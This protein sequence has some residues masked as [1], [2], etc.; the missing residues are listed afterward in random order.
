M[1]IAIL[2]TR[3]IPSNYGGFET[4][5]EE[6][7]VR[8]VQYG[9]QVTV[10]CRSHYVSY[11]QKE[12]RGVHLVI[13]PTIRHKYLD[14]VFHTFLS[15]LHCLVRDYQA[16]LI[17]NAV[18][19]AFSFIPRLRGQKVAVNV[20]GLER[21]RKKWNW[22]G[23]SAYL[24]SEHLVTILPNAIVADSRFIQSYYRNR[25]GKTSTFIAYGG[26]GIQTKQTDALKKYGL[27]KDRYLL[28]VARLEPENN[29]HVVIREFEKVR[30]TM[31]LAMVGDAPYSDSYIGGLKASRDERIRFLG[32][33]YGKPYRQILSH[34]YLSVRASEVGG[35]HPALLEAMGCGKCVLVS[36]N[37]QNRET[38]GRAGVLF[39]L[40]REG[41]LGEKMQYLIDHPQE[42][43][44]YGARA[45]QRVERHYTWDKIARDYEQL[46]KRMLSS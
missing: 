11:S 20:D 42:V 18:N 28:F 29:A 33:I 2:G 27:E 7:A 26:D 21:Q 16:I 10:Y 17:C 36:D 25:Y 37:P 38:L 13:L 3:G 22:L 6:L 45:R 35:T 5:A 41:E 24:F 14:T 43:K 4:F 39:R 1:K 30:T 23:R 19:A 31:N 15:T 46:F 44:R 32:A 12:Y 8:L 9:H 34:C 40:N